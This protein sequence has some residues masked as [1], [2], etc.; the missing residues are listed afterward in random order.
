MVW[1]TVGRV[2]MWSC[3]S[4]GGRWGDVELDGKAGVS[5]GGREVSGKG[6]PN[7]RGLVEDILAGRGR[8]GRG[9]EGKRKRTTRTDGEGELDRE[10]WI[11]CAWP[12]VATSLLTRRISVKHT[13]RRK[14][15]TSRHDT[16]GYLLCCRVIN[17]INFSRNNTIVCNAQQN[18]PSLGFVCEEMASS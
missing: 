2:G 10:V 12:A 7:V 1:V 5:G 3:G 8:D 16:R 9:R 14:F 15:P 11:R 17:L 4:S 13:Q 6:D 18:T